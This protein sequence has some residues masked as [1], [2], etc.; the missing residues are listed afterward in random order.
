MMPRLPSPGIPHLWWIDAEAQEVAP[1][2]AGILARYLGV[3][4][5]DIRIVRNRFGKPMLGDPAP[6]AFNTS[7][8]GGWTVLAI[9]GGEP[10]GVDIEAVQAFPE[11]GA[12]AHVHFAA[13]VAAGIHALP[14]GRRA[15]AFAREWTRLEARLKCAGHGFGR[16]E[17]AS[18]R[19][20]QIVSFSLG[21]IVGA[22]ASEVP[23]M[24][25]RWYR[26]AR[27]QP[28]TSIGERRSGL[29]PIADLELA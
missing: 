12:V 9:S 16:R 25:P 26:I 13:D 4:P 1:W 27:S 21:T 20:G 8:S 24:A 5:A 6:L 14:A 11:L 18:W 7:H 2:R 29:P 23:L 19:E 10:I 15:R 17:T 28:R 22:I 3:L